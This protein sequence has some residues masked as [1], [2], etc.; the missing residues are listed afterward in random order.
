MG[1]PTEATFLWLSANTSYSTPAIAL[2]LLLYVRAWPELDRLTYMDG[3]TWFEMQL[4]AVSATSMAYSSAVSMSVG[5]WSHASQWSLVLSGCTVWQ[6]QCLALKGGQSASLSAPCVCRK[7]AR[8]G[9]RKIAVVDI[10]C[11]GSCPHASA[12]DVQVIG[13]LRAE[14]HACSNHPLAIAADANK[15]V[16]DQR[17]VLERRAGVGGP[18]D[19][20]WAEI[21]SV[22][23]RL[24]RAS[25]MWTDGLNMRATA[26]CQSGMLCTRGFN[27]SADTTADSRPVA[28][29]YGADA[30][31]NLRSCHSQRPCESLCCSC[32][33]F[34]SAD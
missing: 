11:S 20:R 9:Q 26:A 16:L 10:G 27:G 6:S 14:P 22:I 5:G 30:A 29:H 12:L 25:C 19:R 28:V 23:L 4:H 18:D 3:N 15:R 34:D 1:L 13:S 8:D 33:M 31:G 32:R 21:L 24:V 17:A 2:W 7:E